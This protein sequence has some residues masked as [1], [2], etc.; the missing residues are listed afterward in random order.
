MRKKIVI[1]GGGNSIRQFLP[2][3]WED[4]ENTD[5]LAINYSY[6]SMPY[7]PKYLCSLDVLFWKKLADSSQLIHCIKHGIQI[8]AEKIYNVKKEERISL[9]EKTKV[10][11]DSK[12]LFATSRNLSGAFALSYACQNTDYEDIYLLGF[13]FGVQKGK[14]HFYDLKHNG[15]GKERAYL[16]KDGSVSK[17]VEEFEY[18]NKFDK[19]IYLIGDS[20]IQAFPKINYNE[21]KER[22]NNE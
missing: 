22:L 4:I 11:E 2:S 3:L 15:Q 19:N 21:F 18:F 9:F 17:I 16:E 1:V 13:D 14:T 6:L 8:I 12:K 20:N 10:I 5:I 7:I